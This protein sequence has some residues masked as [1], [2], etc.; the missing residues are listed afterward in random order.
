M[1]RVYLCV[2]NP[3]KTNNLGP[4]LR[5]ATAFG[6]DT[7]VTVGYAHCNTEGS[8]GASKHVKIVNFVT[9]E[10]AVRYLQEEC[11]CERVVGLMGALVGGYEKDGCDVIQDSNEEPAFSTEAKQQSSLL[12]RSYPVHGL[13]ASLLRCATVAL[14]V[15]KQ[16]LPLEWARLCDTFVHVPQAS[17]IVAD[18]RLLEHAALIS[19]A[20]Y[21]LVRLDA[22]EHA[23]QGHKFHVVATK[24]ARE[25][26]DDAVTEARAAQRQALLEEEPML[27][28][29]GDE[30]GDY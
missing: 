18:A 2:E 3:R 26:D 9:H 13:P 28:L 24:H 16:S 29:P 23:S 22:H 30:E 12:G 4:L 25:A 21:H 7:L 6:V 15:S 27:R 19:L 8:H 17:R 14:A 10:Q 1:P 5:C 11:G 20:L